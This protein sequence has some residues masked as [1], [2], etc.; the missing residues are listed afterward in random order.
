MELWIR[1]QNRMRL[2]KIGLDISIIP[3][4]NN[5]DE[6]KEYMIGCNDYEMDYEL[7]IYK[8]K[9]RALEV[10]DEIQ[11]KIKWVYRDFDDSPVYEMPVD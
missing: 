3:I 11:E 7:G 10:L 6:I 5:R 4:H 2:F 8:T 9:E 1:S